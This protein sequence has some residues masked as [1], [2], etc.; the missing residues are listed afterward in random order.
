M[1]VSTAIDAYVTGSTDSL[2][3]ELNIKHSK[4]DI[5]IFR[6]RKV[7]YLE[8]DIFKYFYPFCLINCTIASIWIFRKISWFKLGLVT[9]SSI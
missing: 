9:C 7:A 1:D 2:K 8:E 6:L 5:D 3:F 4:K